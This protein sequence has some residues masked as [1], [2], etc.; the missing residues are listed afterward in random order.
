M[1][2]KL[3]L[4]AIAG[5]ARLGTSFDYYKNIKE[6]MGA[7][8][9]NDIL[10][11]DGTS[12]QAPEVRNMEIAAISPDL[13]DITYYSIEPN[14]TKNYH[15][16]LQARKGEF[17]ISADVPVRP[18][19]GHQGSAVPVF[20]VQ[21]QMALASERSL[22]KA[23]AFYFV[24]DK[25]H[26]LTSWLPGPGAFN[27]DLAESL[28]NFGKCA[29]PDD[30]MKFNNPG[31]CVAGGGRTGYSVKMVSRD[32]LLSNQ[33]KIGGQGAGPGGILNP[34]DASGGW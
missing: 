21:E 3:A 32:A 6:D 11:W 7:N 18:D 23:E 34:P 25:V 33:H 4:N 22:Q 26:L 1:K 20:S 10:A 2:S 24:R 9:P 30:R 31:S 12:G 8:S 15:E 17:Q 27:Y 13:F 14:F 19:L 29:V 16:K 5:L 28:R